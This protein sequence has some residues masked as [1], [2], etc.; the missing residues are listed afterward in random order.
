MA[1]RATTLL[2][3]FP[4]AAAVALLSALFLADR[5][6]TARGAPAPG[7]GLAHAATTG[8]L[9]ATGPKTGIYDACFID[10]VR[11]PPQDC[12]AR[13]TAIRDAGFQLVLNKSTG[14]MTLE[15]NLA[16]A[17]LASSRGIKVVW[18]LA[19]YRQPLGLKLDLVRASASHPAT[20]GYYIGEE[21]WPL[22]EQRWQVAELSRAVR[23]ITAKPT[24]FVSRP[25]PYLL[26]PFA[27]LADYVGPDTYPV[28]SNDPPV[29]RTSRWATRLTRNPVIVLQS[30]SWSI[31]YPGMEAGWPS[32]A[33]MR[34]MRDA[35]T[36]CGRPKLIF[37]FCLH[38]VADYHPNPDPYWRK[39]AWAANGITLAPSASTLP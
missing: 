34:R 31:D 14:A 22:L 15:D 33:R 1:T 16:Y 26:R 29:C 10:P 9:K 13:M 3:S 36:R 2:R 39:L 12:G 6:P 7:H 17:D 32:A 4:F 21:V 24:L 5:A 25:Q 28:G 37:W 30:F 18:N 35:A 20:W 23:A 11:Q 19:D 38:C 27:K 8:G